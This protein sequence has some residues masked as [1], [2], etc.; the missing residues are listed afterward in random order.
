MRL[1]ITTVAAVTAMVALAV[2]ASPAA[3]AS[4]AIGGYR[5]GS[6]YCWDNTNGGYGNRILATSPVMDPA[7]TG[8]IVGGSQLTGF[9]VTLQR[10]TGSTWAASQVSA[11]KVRYQSWGFWADEWYD[12]ATGALVS[13]L[14]QFRITTTGYY[15]LVYDLY[16]YT[17][18][19]VSGHDAALAWGMRDDR[20]SSVTT[21]GWSYVDWCRY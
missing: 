9:R 16:W 18:G 1:L 6:G 13:G 3:A 7:Y 11:L 15:R 21:T 12:G 5:T 20:P 2:A 17:N 14:T 4:G 8:S 10:W 19:H